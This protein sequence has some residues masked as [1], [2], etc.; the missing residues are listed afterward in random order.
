MRQSQGER[1]EL[2]QWKLTPDENAAAHDDSTASF[3][4]EARALR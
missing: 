4:S 3:F 1:S 2:D